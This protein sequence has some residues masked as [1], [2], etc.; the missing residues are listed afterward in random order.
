MSNE[1]QKC[2]AINVEIF[3]PPSVEKKKSLKT[4]KFGIAMT[5]YGFLDSKNKKISP[6]KN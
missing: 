5:A 1:E 3:R 2:I 6:R 4:L